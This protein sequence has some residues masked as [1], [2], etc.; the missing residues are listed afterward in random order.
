MLSRRSL[1]DSKVLVQRCT[2]QQDHRS[3]G[4]LSRSVGILDNRCPLGYTH[5]GRGY[6]VY[7]GEWRL[8]EESNIF[9]TSFNTASC[10]GDSQVLSA[11]L[12]R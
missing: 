11:Y 4:M 7:D 12:P 9:E 5:A 3:A 10:F 1:E 2:D 8:G 6:C